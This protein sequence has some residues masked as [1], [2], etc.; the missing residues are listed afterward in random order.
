MVFFHTDHW[1]ALAQY[2]VLA[3][4]RHSDEDRI[5]IEPLEHSE[6]KKQILNLLVSSGIFTKVIYTDS[7]FPGA[8]MHNREE[9]L[10]AVVSTFDDNLLKHGVNADNAKTI[11]STT[12]FQGTFR[13]YL[14]EKG[15]QFV[16]AMMTSWDIYDNYHT[17][18][19]YSVGAVSKEYMDLLN[20]YRVYDGT[21]PFC[22]KILCFP[23][24]P[25]KDLS[26][27]HKFEVFDF[28][29]EI[30]KIGTEWRAK[31][32]N[33]FGI[34]AEAIEN[35]KNLLLSNSIGFVNAVVKIDE[36]C[37]D[38]DIQTQA[39]MYQKL[40]DYY[41]NGSLCDLTIKGHPNNWI[42]WETYFKEC[43]VL[44]CDF[45]IEMVQ[46]VSSAHINK[47]IS[48]ATTSNAKLKDII[49]DP[50]IATADF[51]R[52]FRYLDALY[53]LCSLYS[54][55]KCESRPEIMGFPCRSGYGYKYG[56][57][58]S[59]LKNVM[60]DNFENWTCSDK[61]VF[62]HTQSFFGI[63]YIPNIRE[64]NSILLESRAM[65][66]NS[67]IA[68]L[69]VHDEIPVQAWHSDDF[70]R[71]TV[72]RLEKEP[73]RDKVLQSLE[74]EYVWIFTKSEELRRNI[75]K[76]VVE[77]R[78]EATGVTVISKALSEYEKDLYFENF[79]LKNQS[80]SLSRA[81]EYERKI[82]HIY[83]DL[84]GVNNIEDYLLALRRFDNLIVFFA[85]KDNAGKYY[86][87]QTLWCV[88]NLGLKINWNELGWNSYTAILDSG[89]VVLETRGRR[90]LP[91][92]NEGEI[93]GV[94][95][96]LK[97]KTFQFGNDVVIML[98]GVDYAVKSRGINIVV[99]DKIQKYVVDS[100][101]FDPF[102]KKSFIRRD[103]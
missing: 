2:I 25:I 46:L 33:C 81:Y 28:A 41:F 58:E 97:S 94:G 55:M 71:I 16:N 66:E 65:D 99:Y 21:S 101:C 8:K 3:I 77:K 17:H 86:S 62:N 47:T 69:P 50:V 92:E 76:T 72:F 53:A 15:I 91:T 29:K 31:I 44:S 22:S 102:T 100:V 82:S 51:A 1:G 37:G 7:C 95:Y 63:Y 54:N 4:T 57:F 18:G 32:L 80:L 38:S 43:R 68:V 5:F 60:N 20:E 12:D 70:D 88:E 89:A 45:P 26:Q 79:K 34:D 83:F 90:G 93:S 52:C 9:I 10:S 103:L 67:V 75:E 27:K 40:A 84:R 6:S 61:Y 30:K 59:F 42:E 48:I 78:C 85:V 14:I 64:M 98:N 35:T 11:Y 36:E 24:T 23:E 39:L 87:A 49:D 96:V 13:L 74:H 19:A 56:F 73:F